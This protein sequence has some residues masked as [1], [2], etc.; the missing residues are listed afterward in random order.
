M[1][2]INLKGFLFIAMLP[3]AAC[4]SSHSAEDNS[5]TKIE[6]IREKEDDKWKLLIKGNSTEG[7]HSYLGDSAT[8]WRVE[9][10]VLFTEGKNGDI[11]TDELYE[12]FELS[13]EWKIEEG[14]NSGI[15]YHVIESP[16]YKRIHETGPEFQIIDNENYPADLTEQQKTGALSDVLAPDEAAANAVG[17]WNHTRIIVNQGAVEH[18]L[19]DKKI[20][21][22]QLGSDELKQQIAASKFAELPY[23]KV[24]SGRIGLQDHGGPVYY[25]NIKIRIL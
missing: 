8:G 6:N 20:L 1:K 2:P 4:S 10:G 19:N 24:Q 13:L 23:A 11:V 9:D 18:W 5:S 17:E 16:E 22:Y 7:W 14:G 21:E 12:N 25:K 3:L 15:F